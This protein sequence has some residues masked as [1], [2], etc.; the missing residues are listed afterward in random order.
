MALLEQNYFS[1]GS[2]L[3][4]LRDQHEQLRV[5][6]ADLQN[7][8][9]L[10][11]EQLNL[12]KRE[13]LTSKYEEQLTSLIQDY[14]EMKVERQQLV[15]ECEKRKLDSEELTARNR[16]LEQEYAKLTSNY[17]LVSSLLMEQKTRVA[18]LTAGCSKLEA[19][20]T[21]LK[22]Q[23]DSLRFEAQRTATVFAQK[24]RILQGEVDQLRTQIDERAAIVEKRI[25]EIKRRAD[26]ALEA[27]DQEI[28]N[29]TEA[30]SSLKHIIGG[31]MHG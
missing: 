25:L 28:A 30:N 24:E 8:V 3:A 22:H 18:Q 29:L 10:L 9:E 26:E 14:E 31:K 19:Q 17:E 11:R 7:E 27:K 6:N 20:T 13:S 5:D 15:R 16:E 2:N 23:N 1:Q 12:S 4:A 21:E